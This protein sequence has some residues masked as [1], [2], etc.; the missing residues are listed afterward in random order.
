[1][2]RLFAASAVLSMLAMAPAQ[3]C[4]Y[5]IGNKYGISPEL[6]YAI[7]V[8]ESGLN[9]NAINRGNR[10]GSYDVGLMQI[11]SSWFPKLRRFGITERQLYDPCVNMEVG[12]WILA[13]NVRQHGYSWTA[14]GA[15]NAVDPG[16]R[17][18]YVKRVYMNLPSVA[19]T[20]RP[21]RTGKGK[22][23]RGR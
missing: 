3:A 5:E 18:I 12:A 2:K 13:H 20:T 23:S 22:A 19:G 21:A 17:Q 7:A 4:W 8:T 1:M 16:R 15:Y 11:N 9:P 14:V 6:L 10:N